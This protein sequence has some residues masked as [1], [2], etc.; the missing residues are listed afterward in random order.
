MATNTGLR[1]QLNGTLDVLDAMGPEAEK[2][3]YEFVLSLFQELVD[4]DSLWED[5]A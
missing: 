4:D 1:G 3:D 5:E 2:E